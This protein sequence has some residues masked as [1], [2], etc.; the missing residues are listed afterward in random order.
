MCLEITISY[1]RVAKHSFQVN[2]VTTWQLRRH[3]SLRND[4]K[5]IKFEILAHSRYRLHFPDINAYTLILEK[6]FW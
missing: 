5:Y 6:D 4:K 3:V 1:V 2:V